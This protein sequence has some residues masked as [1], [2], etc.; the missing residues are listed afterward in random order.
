MKDIK[1]LKAAI[2][3]STDP[4]KDGTV[5]RWT[6]LT[7]N[8]RRLTY[9]AMRTSAGWYTTATPANPVIPMILPYSKLT[10][11]LSSDDVVEVEVAAEWEHVR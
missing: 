2:A 1:A 11:I 10:Q 8:G 5:I 7:S 9:A 3:A 4:M 6:S